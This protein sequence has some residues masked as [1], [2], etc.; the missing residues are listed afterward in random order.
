MRVAIAK[1]GDL[2]R[3]LDGL[4]RPGDAGRRDALRVIADLD[5]SRG[6]SR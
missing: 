6:L 5:R 2:T 4:D 3:T 1:A